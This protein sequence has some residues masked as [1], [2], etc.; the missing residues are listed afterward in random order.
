MCRRGEGV[1]SGP[2][3]VCGG[4]HCEE[5]FIAQGGIVWEEIV[6]SVLGW[7][8]RGFWAPTEQV[9]QNLILRLT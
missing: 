9:L 7:L 8:R 3:F 5:I 4:Q 6:K 2:S 1:S